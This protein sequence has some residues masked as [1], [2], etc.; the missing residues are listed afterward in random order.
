MF[1][2]KS[3]IATIAYKPE[4]MYLVEGIVEPSMFQEYKELAECM[5]SLSAKGKAISH[6]AIETESKRK[7]TYDN[8]LKGLAQFIRSKDIEVNAKIVSDRY[9]G[10]LFTGEATAAMMEIEEGADPLE[11]ITDFNN[12]TL[13]ITEGLIAD[14][15]E[16]LDAQI[17]ET[18]RRIEK[19]LECKGLTGIDTGI[20][21]LN[22]FTG[23][24]QRGGHTIIAGR[25]GMGKTALM[26]DF[27]LCAIMAKVPSA[28]FSWEMT[29]QE[30]LQRLA[31]KLTGISTL[32]MMNG[33]LTSEESEK[34]MLALQELSSMPL[35]IID[36]PG[37]I[38]KVRSRYI[39]LNKTKGTQFYAFDYVQRIDFKGDIREAMTTASR[40]LANT[41]KECDTHNLLLSQLSRSVE[42]RGGDKRP[43]LQD[44]KETGALE[45]DAKLVIFPYRAE[46][47]GINEDEEGNS[48]IGKADL[49]IPKNREGKTGTIVGISFEG[50]TGQFKEYSDNDADFMPTPESNTNMRTARAN[51]DLDDIPF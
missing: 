34:V 24:W 35:T 14:D 42:S 3:I 31:S 29:A 39:I 7:F 30:L 22:E 1:A 5:W 6:G 17:I 23:G 9:Y 51:D 50:N 49:I 21:K 18:Q 11:V 12:K 28:I 2:E 41:S 32:K 48:L 25:P 45:E 26:L 38:A 15:S 33:T 8:T 47:Y 27:V 43:M 13:G 44:L 10:S 40:T 20:N 19:A 46:Y 4:L 16:D 37:G 36:K